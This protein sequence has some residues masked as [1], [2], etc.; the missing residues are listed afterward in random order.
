MV[1]S[2]ICGMTAT[3]EAAKVSKRVVR[4]EITSDCV[5]VAEMNE[6]LPALSLFG[7]LVPHVDSEIYR[8]ASEH[9]LCASC[10]VPMAIVKAIEVETGIV[11]PGSVSVHFETA[12]PD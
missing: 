4:V 2:G 5:K 10:P 3:I 12:D 6:S 9:H 11:L 8:C 1:N 7:V